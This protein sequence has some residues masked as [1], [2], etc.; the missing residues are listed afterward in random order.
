MGHGNLW[1]PI[2]EGAA[3]DGDR[4]SRRQGDAD[5]RA[6]G[7]S[8]EPLWAGAHGGDDAAGGFAAAASLAVQSAGGADSGGVVVNVPGESAAGFG[9]GAGIDRRGGGEGGILSGAGEGG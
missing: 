1:Q 3:H 4:I 5:A 8:T 6:R 7:A 9:A 2:C